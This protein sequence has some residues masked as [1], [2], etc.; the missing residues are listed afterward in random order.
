M[1]RDSSSL[2]SPRLRSVLPGIV[3]PA[4]PEPAAAQILGLLFQ[5]ERTQWLPPDQIA[6]LQRRQMLALLTHAARHVPFYRERFSSLGSDVEGWTSPERWRQLPILTRADLQ[7]A[8]AAI[9]SENLPAAH[10]PTETVRSSGSTGRPVE[11]QSTA[12]TRL[13]WAVFTLR[14]HIWHGR[15][16]RQSLASIR[17]TKEGVA[18]YPEGA[19]TRDWGY[20]VGLMYETGPAAVLSVRTSTV[21]QQLDWLA[22]VD[23]EVLLTY[24]SVA[25]E[26]A[27][28]C[29]ATGQGVPSLREVRL[30]GE[31][32]DEGTRATLARAWPV[33]VTDV[34]SA[35]E[36][37]YIALQCPTGS[38]YHVQAEGVL[39]EVL[40]D[41]GK[42]C[43]PG[44]IGRVVVT[45]LHNFATPLIRYELGD[46]AEVGEPCACGR[47]LPVLR[48]ILGRFRNLLVLPSGARRWP[49]FGWVNHAQIAPVTQFQMV[50]KGLDH[51]EVRVVSRRPL[52]RAEERSFGD[53]IVE[54]LG[55]PFRLTFTAVD[56]VARSPS[57]KFED[58]LSE[59]PHPGG[60]TP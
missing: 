48:R 53:Q 7:R 11:G 1:D 52:S 29:V 34:Y 43:A 41:A 45:A 33:P 44:E 54:H 21:E 3:W 14:E 9:L 15:D 50:Q 12:V 42:P 55:Y 5:L 20:P 47:G 26:L 46:F 13:F 18:D 16:F 8:G 59:L 10:R 19:R 17:V 57:G 27:R 58:F 37:G 23:P 31:A 30:F 35:N 4:A 39:V 2:A 38:H 49:T 56:H 25:E 28:A 22:R 60:G 36:V 40:D 6:T 32:V 51:I 24:P